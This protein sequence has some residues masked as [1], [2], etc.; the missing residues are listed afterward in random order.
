MWLLVPTSIPWLA[1]QIP[2]C[3]ETMN[4]ECSQKGYIGSINWFTLRQKVVHHLIAA[5]MSVVPSAMLDW[6]N[7]ISIESTPNTFILAH[8]DLLYTWNHTRNTP[9]KKMNEYIYS[10]DNTWIYKSN[11]PLT[12]SCNDCFTN[13]ITS[14]IIHHMQCI[15]PNHHF[16]ANLT[17]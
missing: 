9:K 16:Y 11:V 2:Y 4:Y 15:A 10:I 8:V 14:Y 7:F 3:V 12:R 6:I 17:S 13:E 5:Y 1:V